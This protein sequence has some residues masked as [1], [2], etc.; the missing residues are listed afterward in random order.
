MSALLLKW[1]VEEA[2]PTFVQAGLITPEE[3]QEI[4]AEMEDAVSNPD[5]LALAPRVSLVAAR[6]LVNQLLAVDKFRA[7]GLDSSLC[8]RVHRHGSMKISR[9]A[10]S[11]FQPGRRGTLA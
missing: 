7:S 1:S 2:G 3:L 8:T 6:K 11:T 5:V 10:T 4:I 9:G